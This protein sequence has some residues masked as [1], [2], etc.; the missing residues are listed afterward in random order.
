MYLQES[1][2]QVETKTSWRLKWSALEIASELQFKYFNQ[3]AGIFLLFDY[4]Y[5]SLNNLM[6][7]ITGRKSDKM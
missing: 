7:V 6:Y 3:T 2:T 4:K 5:N 1:S